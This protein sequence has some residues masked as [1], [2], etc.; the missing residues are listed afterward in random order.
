MGQKN[1]NIIDKKF[2]MKVKSKYILKRIFA[3]IQYTKFLNIIRYNKNLQSKLNIE[4]NDYK[5]YLKTEIEIIPKDSVFDKIINVKDNDV[6]YFHFYI[7][8][9][10][11]EK[12]FV[13]LFFNC[14]IR[15]IKI[16]IDY[17]VKSFDR[18]FG[19]CKN[20]KK[21]KFIKFNRKD[22][23]NITRIF[24]GCDSLIEIDLSK[25][26]TTYINNM[27]SMFN[28]C[29][30]LKYL[31][32]SN[33]NTHN[34]TNMQFMFY[35]CSSLKNLNISSF[36]TSNVTSMYSMFQSC[37]NL[38]ELDLS[39]FNTKNLNNMGF[40]F[41]QCRHLEKLD[42]SNFNT[43]NVTNMSYMFNGCNS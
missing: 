13:Y 36:D 39:N 37:Y 27:S 11:K 42:L 30:S 5:E 3:H 8:D 24:S 21:L 20:I 25:F 4:L 16:I 18:L 41:Y 33:F 2:L 9:D 26:N 10:K 34:V 43:S 23:K 12:N 40:M 7:N 19:G 38:I 17:E 6:P 1:K 31:N 15:K 28:R 29:E 32:L 35:N 22:I 14:S